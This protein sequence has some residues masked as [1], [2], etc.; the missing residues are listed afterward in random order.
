[1]VAGSSGRQATTGD[2]LKTLALVLVPIVVI[3]ILFTRLPSDHP[4]K[5]LDWKPVLATARHEAPYRVL[6][7]TN[8][9]DGW[10][11]TA[12]NWVKVG[13]PYLGKPSV[14]NLWQLGMLSPDDVYLSIVQGDLQPDDLVREQTR[15]GVPDGSSTV[16]GQTWERRVSPDDRTRSLVRSDSTVTTIVVGDTSYTGLEAF[17]GTLS[18]S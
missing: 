1:V 5:A 11:A 18:D 7:P 14:R 15:A 2:L 16:D 10:R 3:A 9:P 6:A 17:A 8:L 13:E 12:V 4:V